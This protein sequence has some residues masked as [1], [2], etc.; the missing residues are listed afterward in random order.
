MGKMEMT[1]F[2][3]GPGNKGAAGKGDQRENFSTNIEGKN[4]RLKKVPAGH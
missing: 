4:K 1:G 2:L 3:A